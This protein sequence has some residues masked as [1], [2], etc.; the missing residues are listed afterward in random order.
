[1]QRCRQ[2]IP[3]SRTDV[4]LAE[5]VFHSFLN[6]ETKKRDRRVR[7][8]IGRKCQDAHQKTSNI[9]TQFADYKRQYVGYSHKG[10]SYMCIIAWHK[11]V[12]YRD[13]SKPMLPSM[14]VWAGD[15]YLSVFVD[16]KRK[17]VKRLYIYIG[18]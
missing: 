15:L 13:E 16:Y 14:G 3:P 7:N 17:R 18:M 4:E 10:R 5:S 1:M 6:K 9:L 11:S 8:C 2:H 12:K